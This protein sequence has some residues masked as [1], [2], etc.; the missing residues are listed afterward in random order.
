M[1][2]H[3]HKLPKFPKA[4]SHEEVL[5]I[6]DKLKTTSII[7]VIIANLCLY[8]VLWLAGTANWLPAFLFSAIS[9]WV[10][11]FVVLPQIDALLEGLKKP[12]PLPIQKIRQQ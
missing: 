8:F 6:A 3:N 5:Q 11:W 4:L 2:N 7:L 12:R 1:P 10:E 9:I